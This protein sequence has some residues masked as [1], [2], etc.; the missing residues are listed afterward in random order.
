MVF[1][2]LGDGRLG[3]VHELGLRRHDGIHLRLM[4][5]V[6]PFVFAWGS[7]DVILFNIHRKVLLALI[8]I[9]GSQLVMLVLLTS[10]WLRLQVSRE[11]PSV[12]LQLSHEAALT[13]G[14]G[15]FPARGAVELAWLVKRSIEGVLALLVPLTAA[16]C[17]RASLVGS[18]SL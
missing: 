2:S 6:V 13:C 18:R 3:P 11:L 15:R 5:K 8:R 9:I 14:V 17:P 4:P 10:S 7:K 1:A 12:L 16:C